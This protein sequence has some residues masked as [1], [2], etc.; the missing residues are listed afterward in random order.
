MWLI[1]SHVILFLIKK[2]DEGVMHLFAILPT[3]HFYEFLYNV[4]INFN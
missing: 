4:K 1:Y 3:S 2:V